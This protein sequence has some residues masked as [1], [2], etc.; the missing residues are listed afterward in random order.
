MVR[1]VALAVLATLALPAAARANPAISVS[2]ERVGSTASLPAK[3][4]H[5]LTLTAGATEEQV[6]VSVFPSAQ[7]T[8]GGDTRSVQTPPGGA[9]PSIAICPGQ[10]S[11]MRPHYAT[12]PPVNSATLT[13]APGATAFVEATIELVRAP[14]E[15]EGLDATWSIEPAQGNGFEV[16]SVAPQYSGPLGVELEFQAHRAPD[17]HYVVAGTAEPDVDS[18]RVELWAYAPKAKRATRIASVRPRIGE[19]SYT[20]FLPA[21]KG[22]WELYARYRTAGRSYANDASPC[23]TFI[24]VR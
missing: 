13:L 8:V 11:N 15:D 5:R 16:S 4:K 12:P 7:L 10:W 20:R 19:W 9:G 21:R 6:T 18:G 14:W 17:G 24:T 1:C 3:V 22:R 23:G 2:S